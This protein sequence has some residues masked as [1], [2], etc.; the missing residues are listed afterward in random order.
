MGKLARPPL[1]D[2]AQHAPIAFIRRRNVN[3]TTQWAHICK[4]Q[5]DQLCLMNI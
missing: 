5:P 2:N 1:T 4:F 3:Y